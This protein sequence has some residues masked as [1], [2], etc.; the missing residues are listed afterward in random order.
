MQLDR[1]QTITT[2][3]AIGL[4]FAAIVTVDAFVDLGHAR[5]EAQADAAVLAEGRAGHEGHPGL[6]E[7]GAGEAQ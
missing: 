7:G 3:A 1:A 2:G 5:G 6:V 4:L